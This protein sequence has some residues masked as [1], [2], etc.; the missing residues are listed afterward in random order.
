M[1]RFAI[2][3]AAVTLVLVS[4]PAALAG[5]NRAD[6]FYTVTCTDP[7]GDLVEAE[8]V[9]AHAIEQGGK[10]MGIAHW[11]AAHPG[12]ECHVEGPFRN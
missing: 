4:A 5:P 9:D 10:L 2:G 12:Y 3:A 11:E 1:R 6:T 7:N 8:S